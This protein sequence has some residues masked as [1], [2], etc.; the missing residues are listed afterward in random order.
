MSDLHRNGALS[1]NVP[2][3]ARDLC[4]SQGADGVMGL[5]NRQ[6][7]VKPRKAGFM[8]DSGLT[9]IYELIN[10]GE[11]V[12]YRDGR[13]RLITV[14]SIHAYVRRR[15]EASTPSVG[16][17]NPD[18]VSR[19]VSAPSPQLPTRP[20]LSDGDGRADGQARRRQERLNTAPR[21]APSKRATGKQQEA[22]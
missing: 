15:I 2:R 11:L 4:E 6:L 14:E 13:S 22:K 18:Q 17:L 3:P 5:Q 20:R 1:R 10:A 16:K 7:V 19:E 8:L 12:S 21:E 9:R